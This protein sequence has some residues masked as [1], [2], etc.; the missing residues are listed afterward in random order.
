MPTKGKVTKQS[1]N[2]RR[3]TDPAKERCG[4]CSMYAAPTGSKTMAPTCTLVLGFI[5]PLD[6]CDRWEKK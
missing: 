5:S 2:Y 3:A 6:V 4:N 1:V